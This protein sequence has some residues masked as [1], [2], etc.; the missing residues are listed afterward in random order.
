MFYKYTQGQA[1]YV[2]LSVF[3]PPPHTCAH[4]HA[5]TYMD[6]QRG[7][8][9]LGVTGDWGWAQ[10]G[11][12]LNRQTDLHQPLTGRPETRQGWGLWQARVSH[13]PTWVPC[14]APQVSQEEGDRGGEGPGDI[15]SSTVICSHSLTLHGVSVWV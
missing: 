6:K 1:K 9:E 11:L 7:T 4:T 15:A 10:G 13:L 5:H 3:V 8:A 14:P 2:H 12:R